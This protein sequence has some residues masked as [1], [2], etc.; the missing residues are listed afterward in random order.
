MSLRQWLRFCGIAVLS[1]ALSSTNRPVCA[2]PAVSEAYPVREKTYQ[3]IKPVLDTGAA[4]KRNLEI[5]IGLNEDSSRLLS[6]MWIKQSLDTSES[7]L[8][9]IRG[10]LL[11]EFFH[12]RVYVQ[13][14]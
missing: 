12:G 11:M 8:V 10:M 7:Y 1:M 5:L 2:A 4:F 9:G 13:G 3:A 14:R 6:L